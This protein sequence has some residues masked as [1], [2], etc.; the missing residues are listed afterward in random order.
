MSAAALP[1]KPLME[2]NTVRGRQLIPSKAAQQGSIFMGMLVTVAIVAILLMETG[3]VWSSVIRREREAQLLAQGNEIRRAIG[4]YYDVQKIY[5][6]TLEELLLDKRQPIIKRYLRRLYK[7]PMDPTQEWGVVEGPGETIMG[8]FS[9]AKGQPLKR[10]NFR[11]GN[12][13]FIGQSSYQGW[14]FLYS[15]GQSNPP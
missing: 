10:G 2:R 9:Q 13:T 3:Q 5:P 12:E 11:K 6:K 15:P 1:A 8:V 4:L 14:I 7:D